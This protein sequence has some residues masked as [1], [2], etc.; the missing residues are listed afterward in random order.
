MQLRLSDDQ[1]L[2]VDTT[3]RFLA[4]TCD[5]TAVRAFATTDAGFDADWWR[6]GAELGWTSLL[7]PE[8]LGGGGVSDDALS[9]LALIAYERGRA[10]APGPFAGVNA[11][12]AALADATSDHPLLG[13]LVAGTAIASLA[14]DERGLRW[15]GTDATTTC[16]VR[17]D[18]AMVSGRKILV[19]SATESDAMLVLTSGTDGLALVVVPTGAD[20]VEISPRRTP[21]L[22][23]RFADVALED[24]EV[25]ADAVLGLDRS[26]IER[27]L[28]IGTVLQL[29]ETVG[30][31][32][33][34]LQFTIEWAFDRHSF[35]RPL[36][37]YQELKHRFADMTL[38]L[39]AS[40]ATVVEAAAALGRGAADAPELVSTAVSYVDEHGPELVQ[41]CVQMHGGIGVTWE[42]DIHLYLR[43]VTLNS[44]TYGTVAD[45]RE[46]LAAMVLEGAKP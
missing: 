39:E 17:G 14:V 41:D 8:E 18:R 35:G 13:M 1:S 21:D 19:E 40:K 4:D 15:P 6:R 46:R 32:D 12:V 43:R 45:H 28:D 3:R 23:R 42:H 26:A 11:V 10:V 5:T 9:D 25:G 34:V 31:L 22:V 44:L 20:G 2:F 27:V 30:A 37:S 24:V 33:R 36:A 16:T 7:A 29:A 38:W